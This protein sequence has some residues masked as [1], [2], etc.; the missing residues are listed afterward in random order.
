MALAG[1]AGRLT[2][3]MLLGFAMFAAVIVNIAFLGGYHVNGLGS[4]TGALGLLGFMAAAAVDRGTA[5]PRR[6]VP[7]RRGTHG[8]L[9]RSAADR[10]GVRR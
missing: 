3:G 5:L 6:A 2:A 10:R 7:H 9:D 1:A 4:V 8:H